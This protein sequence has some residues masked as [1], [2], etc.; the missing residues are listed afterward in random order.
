MDKLLQIVIREP[1]ETLFDGQ[2]KSFSSVNET[3][4]F[5]VLPSHAQFVATVGE[6]IKLVLPDGSEKSFDIE[7]GVLRVKG[8][9]I[10]VYL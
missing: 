8:D 4:A 7:E 6:Y 10:E 9:V 3:G 5:D 1:Q 2:A